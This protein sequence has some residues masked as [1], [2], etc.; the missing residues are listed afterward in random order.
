MQVDLGDHPAER[1]TDIL[2]EAKHAHTVYEQ[3]L[4]HADANWASWYARHII[5]R[6][7]ED[8]SARSE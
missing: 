7:T 1:L 4:G 6:L 3:R 8:E 5:D 2:N